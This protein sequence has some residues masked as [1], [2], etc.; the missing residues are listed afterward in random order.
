[1][2]TATKAGRFAKD[3]IVQ[4]LTQA[5]QERQSFFIAAIGRLQAVEADALRKRLRPLQARLL[6]AK[7][8]LSLRGIATL[9][10]NGV[11]SLFAGSVALVLP[12]EDVLPVAKLL[13]DFAKAN[14][15]KLAI[16]GGWIE[17]QLLDGKQVEELAVLPPR[18]QL[19]AQVVG[20]IESPIAEVILTLEAVLGDVAWVLEE[21][22]K[23]R[24]TKI[25]KEEQR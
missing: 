13:V 21:A 20:A 16:R 22:A 17:G 23:G 7:R 3:L 14:Q 10:L 9:K 24:D 11:S 15:D 12:G 19:I 6:V 18:L 2:A 25:N 4:E 8:T 1:M 5:L